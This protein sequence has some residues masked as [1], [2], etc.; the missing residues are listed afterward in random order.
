MSDVLSKL[1]TLLQLE[2]LEENLF[3]GQSQDL[4]WGVVFGGQVLGQALSAAEQTVPTE[5]TVHSFHGYFLRPGD[6]SR[7]VI[8]EVDPIRD[9]KSFTTRRVVGIQNGK[10]IF[11]MSAS[12]HRHEEGYDHQDPMPD[13]KR[14]DELISERELFAQHLDKI[15]KPLQQRATAERPIEIKPVHFDNPLKP[16]PR[17]PK[18]YVWYRSNGPLP[19]T[20]SVHHYLLAYASDF[21]FLATALQP[22]GQSW[23]TGTQLA[24][25]DHSM[26]FHRPFRFDDYL[27]YAVDSPTAQGARGLVRGQFFAPDGTLVAST[28]QE[29]LMRKRLP[30]DQR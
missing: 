5:R 15:P 2:R 12:F 18:R 19:D 14:P 22:H 16:K 9:G 21:H 20:P 4:G 1:L 23:L 10:A 25:L 6:V 29:G 24:S 28:A 17:E 13:V 26:W 27:L 11:N 7:P 30:R 8:Y 3:R